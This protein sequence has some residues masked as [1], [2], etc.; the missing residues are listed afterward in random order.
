MASV[1]AVETATAIQDATSAELDAFVAK[2]SPEDLGKLSVALGPAGAGESI[3]DTLMMGLSPDQ[4]DGVLLQSDP[5]L[6]AVIESDEYKEQCRK[7]FEEMDTDRNGVLNGSELAQAVRL[8]VPGQM[9][10][11]MQ[12][13]AD[14]ISRAI[15]SFE[16]SKDGKVGL[17]DFS[18]FC[19]WVFARKMLEAM[20][21]S[22]APVA[23][24]T[25]EEV[26]FYLANFDAGVQ[27]V[28]RSPEFA[29]EC[30]RTFLEIDTN[31]SGALDGEDLAQ[32][33]CVALAQEFCTRMNID[34]E[35]MAQII[36]TFDANKN[37]K[38]EL[39]EFSRFCRWVLALYAVQKRSW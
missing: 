30:S 25:E 23:M 24:M 13:T 17:A 29:E 16:A 21:G 31:K 26:D 11:L 34:G 8:V 6:Q 3:V 5:I 36:M 35:K 33:L 2:L 7:S 12:L 14:N 32:A 19:K 15:G 28:L 20:E 27:V 1:G 10:S 18:N 37:D 4:V 39:D 22:D 38:I 9:R